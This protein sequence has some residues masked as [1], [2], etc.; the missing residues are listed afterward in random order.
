MPQSSLE[1]RKRRVLKIIRALK[2]LFPQPKIALH[3]SNHWELL[4]AVILSAQCTDKKVN[5]VTARLFKKYKKLNDYIK[6]RLAEFA[7][8][9]KS[10]GLYRGKAKNILASAKIIK[11]KYGG[12]IPKTMEELIHLPGVGRKTANVVLGTAY[13]SPSGIAVDTHVRRLSRLLGLTRETDPNKI[14]QDLIKIIPKQEWIDFTYRM[15]E[16]GRKYCPARPHNHSTCPLSS[17]MR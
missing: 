12:E 6:A 10:I 16:Y 9:I 7:H 8:D 4:V 5:E 11:E 3:Y 17:F 15:I 14:E 13:R 2:R 1:A